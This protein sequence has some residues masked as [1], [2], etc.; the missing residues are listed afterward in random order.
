MPVGDDG[1][2]GETSSE[3]EVEGSKADR[4][5]DEKREGRPDSG[6]SEGIVHRRRCT[7]H[8]Y[9]AYFCPIMHR[10]LNLKYV[11]Q[12]PRNQNNKKTSNLTCTRVNLIPCS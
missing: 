6:P 5:G 8:R 11:T 3:R 2:G 9:S 10:L 7:R 4:E 1:G 12:W